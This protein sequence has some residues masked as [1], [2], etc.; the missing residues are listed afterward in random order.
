MSAPIPLAEEPIEAE[1][2]TIE[3][4]V[5]LSKESDTQ[6]EAGDHGGFMARLPRRRRLHAPLLTCR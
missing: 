3:K 1:K 4:P 2:K 6:E 5:E